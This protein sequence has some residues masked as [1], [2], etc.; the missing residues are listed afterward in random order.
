MV[1]ALLL[2]FNPDSLKDSG[3]KTQELSKNL[4][5][6]DKSRGNSKTGLLG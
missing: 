1:D 3:S 2:D 5:P 4:N 6:R